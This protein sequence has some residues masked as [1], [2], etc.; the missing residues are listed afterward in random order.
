MRICFVRLIHPAY[1]RN[2]NARLRM[3]RDERKAYLELN[4][5]ERMM[6]S[7]FTR[8]VHPSYKRSLEGVLMLLPVRRKAFATRTARWRG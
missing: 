5:T 3:P 1:G 2:L 4:E 7:Y 6:R 8:L